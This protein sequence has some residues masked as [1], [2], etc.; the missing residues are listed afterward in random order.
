MSSNL[1]L[2]NTIDAAAER[3]EDSAEQALRPSSPD[4]EREARLQVLERYLSPERQRRL[5]S[6]LAKRT[7]RLTV[8]V[9]GVIDLGNAAAIMRSCEAM[10]LH[11]AFFV[12]RGWQHKKPS[13]GSQ[14]AHKWMDIKAFADV[15]GC[16][17][18]VK[19]MGYRLIGASLD[20]ERSL[21][22]LDTSGKVAFVLG[23]EHD[24]L[25]EA[26]LQRCDERYR[27]DM[28]G[29]VQSLNV[30]VAAAISLFHALNQETPEQRGQLDPSLRDALREDFYRK[31]VHHSEQILRRVLGA[32][33][34]LLLPSSYPESMKLGTL[35][36]RRGRVKNES[37]FVRAS[38]EH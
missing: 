38:M 16:V 25:S 12:D 8:V 28:H 35:R 14:G 6:A 7:E 37:P 34:P 33:P 23:S 13:R 32:V 4:P 22:E 11:R 26:M 3:C 1:D 15:D 20:A 24:G 5:E 21:T 29:L 27:I 18:C 30:A 17:E 10:G 2:E 9:D 36:S 31:A 19:G